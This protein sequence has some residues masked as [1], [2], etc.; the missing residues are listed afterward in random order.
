MDRHDK[1]MKIL[2]GWVRLVIADIACFMILM[3]YIFVY[4]KGVI[5]SF[6]VGLCTTGVVCGLLADYILKFSSK[7]KDNVKYKG[8]PDCRHFGFVMG[9]VLMLPGLAVSIVALLAYLE[10]IPRK[11]CA[12]FHLFN[13]YFTPIVDIPIHGNIGNPDNYNIWAIVLMYFMQLAIFF[14]C[15]VVYRVGYEN[16][17]VAEKVMYKGRDNGV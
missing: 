10:A 5:V 13:S 15:A 4:G 7:V 17:D 1:L 11:W 6:L 16:I 14:T 9:S 2:G 3:V 8:K 12:I